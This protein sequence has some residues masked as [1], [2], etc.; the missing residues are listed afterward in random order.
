LIQ[1]VFEDQRE[2]CRAYFDDLFVFTTTDSMTGHLA[3]LDKVL[4]RCAEQQLYVKLSKCTFC[5]D[6]IP[7]LGDYIGRDGIRMDPDKLMCIRD[8]PTPR[9]KR[10]LQSLLGTC[11]YVL[12]YCHE[13]AA[14]SAPLTEATKGKTKHEK[15]ALDEEHRCF[16]ELKKRLFSPPILSHPDTTRPFHVKMDA[17]DY[18]VGATSSNSTRMDVNMSSPME[19]G[20]LP[21]LNGCTRHAKRSYWQRYTP[22]ARER[23]T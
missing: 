23:S 15:I 9:T 7:C 14:L 2:F 18:A 21:Q 8:W 6:E 5:A 4:A 20:S 12:K 3:A 10:E 19:A 1:T 17:S 11:V 22:C 16:E 13:F